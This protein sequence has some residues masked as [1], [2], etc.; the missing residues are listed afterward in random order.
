MI[1]KLMPFDLKKKKEK[2]KKTISEIV[3]SVIV[4]SWLRDGGLC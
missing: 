4:Y 1:T 3:Q 2:L